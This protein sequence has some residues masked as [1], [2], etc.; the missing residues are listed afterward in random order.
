MKE[1][2]THEDYITKLLKRNIH[3]FYCTSSAKFNAEYIIKS[4]SICLNP[5]IFTINEAYQVFLNLKKSRLAVLRTHVENIIKFTEDKS[6]DDKTKYA[7][8]QE[9]VT[10]SEGKRVYF[11]FKEPKLSV[12][13]KIGFE[14]LDF[15]IFPKWNSNANSNCYFSDGM[16]LEDLDF[17]PEFPSYF[18]LNN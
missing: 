13:E 1:N 12:V 15:C 10:F 11:L 7:L 2:C 5:D 4:N 6:I 16:E 14:Y 18:L 8:M 17:I 3:V 9:T